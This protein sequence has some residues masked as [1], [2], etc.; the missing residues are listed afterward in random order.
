MRVL[1][2]VWRVSGSPALVGGDWSEEMES[3]D[4]ETEGDPGG[5]SMNPSSPSMSVPSTRVDID[6]EEDSDVGRGYGILGG[7]YVELE[8]LMCF[9][10]FCGC[11]DS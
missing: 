4:S 2:P 5:E 11:G 10:W 6:E 9:G 7:G 3:E 8:W 1:G